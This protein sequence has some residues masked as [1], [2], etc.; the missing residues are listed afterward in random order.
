MDELDSIFSDD[1]GDDHRSGTV[2]VVGRPNV[3]KSTLINAILGQKIAIVTAKP[4]TTRQRQLGIYTTETAQIL[5]ADTPG[6][7]KPQTRL[8]DFMVNV[9]QNALKD[10]D[11]ILWIQDVSRAP[12]AEDQHIADLLARFAHKKKKI[13]ILNKID[14][15]SDEHDRGQ[16]LALVTAD[17]VVETSAV[18]GQGIDTL[19]AELLPLLPVGPRYYPAEQVSE[20]NLRFLAAEI[21]REKIIELTSEELPYA[22][23]VEITSFREKDDITIIEACIYVERGS[24][25]GIVIGRGGRMIKRIGVDARADLENLLG[26]QVHL[27]TT[28]KVLRNWRS[29]E[30]FMRRVGYILPKAKRRQAR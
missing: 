13:L 4:Q 28:V 16:H 15:V 22:S 30:E 21:V 2:A 17:K 12:N 14:L 23:A 9:A 1:W 25:K 8:G 29:N 19:M 10:A 6:I 26:V 27:E 18:T 7:H 24:Q 20:A 3:G 11:V 5:F